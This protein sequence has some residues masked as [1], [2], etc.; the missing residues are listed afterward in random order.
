MVA[1][2]QGLIGLAI[3]IILLIVVLL[4]GERLYHRMASGPHRQFLM[5]ALVSFCCNLF[6]LTLND[7]VETDKL[8]SFF[9]FSIAVVI[10]SSLRLPSK[11]E[12]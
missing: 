10:L 8:G 12:T 2:E 3:F 6:V 4:Y 9:F 5:A 7:M 1:V 11:G